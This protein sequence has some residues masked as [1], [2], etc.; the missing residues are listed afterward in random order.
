MPFDIYRKKNIGET[1]LDHISMETM[2]FSAGY[3]NR[4]F[5][6]FTLTWVV[7]FLILR[8]PITKLYLRTVDGLILFAPLV[9]ILAM[10]IL[11]FYNYRK[12]ALIWVVIRRF[13]L[14]LTLKLMIVL[15]LFYILY[16]P[17][18]FWMVI[19]PLLVY[20]KTALS[21]EGIFY[22]L[23]YFLFFI[24][25][26]E[27]L[28]VSFRAYQK[29]KG[30]YLG[31]IEIL[32]KKNLYV[33]FFIFF[34]IFASSLAAYPEAYNPVFSVI[35]D[36]I[37]T[38][39]FG[40]APIFNNEEFTKYKRI[41][42][43]GEFANTVSS[44]ISETAKELSENNQKFKI[45]IESVEQELRNSFAKV[46]EDFEEKI[47]T[48][49]ETAAESV[50]L[51]GGTI[52]ADTL[53]EGSLTMD[54]VI[55]SNSIIPTNTGYNLGSSR[56]F[57]DSLYVSLIFGSGG[58]KIGPGSSNQG[59]SNSED[60]I[61]TGNLE[62][63][64]AV[65]FDG[66]INMSGGRMNG[67][68]DIEYI[69]DDEPEYTSI[70][71]QDAVSLTYLRENLSPFYYASD[72][73]VRPRE[74][75]QD[76]SVK[77]C[78]YDNP[79][80]CG[81]M[82]SL[83]FIG[84]SIRPRNGSENFQF[85]D[86]DGD[87][88]VHFDTVNSRVWI[89]S[90][91]ENINNSNPDAGEIYSLD[92]A[93]I[94]KNGGIYLRHATTS[95]YSMQIY[96]SVNQNTVFG[97]PSFLDNYTAGAR[98]VVFGMQAARRNVSGE[99]NVFFGYGAGLYNTVGLR[100]IGIGAY[101]LYN[102]T[103]S[104]NIAIGYYSLHDNT[105]GEKNIAIAARYAMD[106]NSAGS[107]NIALGG[108]G[109]LHS[110]VEGDDNI[111]IGYFN[112]YYSTGSRN[113]SIGSS[114]LQQTQGGNDNTS[115]GGSTSYISGLVRENQT[116]IGSSGNSYGCSL[117]SASF[118]VGALYCT[119]DSLQTRD[120]SAFG[121]QALY[122]NSSENTGTVEA[123]GVNDF[124]DEEGSYNSYFGYFTN[125]A[126]N[127]GRHNSIFGSIALLLNST[128]VENT[129]F[130]YYAMASY[131]DRTDSS[132]NTVIGAQALYSDGTGSLGSDYNV[133]FGLNA[134]HFNGGNYNVA[135]G[136]YSLFDNLGDENI[137]FGFN[138]GSGNS[139]ATA[140][141]ELNRNLILGA[142][143]GITFQTPEAN[144]D[145][146][147]NILAGSISGT[148]LYSGERNIFLGY[149][150]SNNFYDGSFNIDI[151]QSVGAFSGIYRIPYLTQEDW[152]NW[153]TQFLLDNPQYEGVINFGEFIAWMNLLRNATGRYASNTLNIGNLIFGN[154]IDGTAATI[155]TGNI[156]I[157]TNAPEHR[158]TVWKDSPEPDEILFAI[159]NGTE[160]IFTVDEDGD[161]IYESSITQAADYAEHF[162]S[163]DINL[164]SGEAVCVDETKENAVKR[165]AKNGDS[166]IIGVVSTKPA[167]VGNRTDEAKANPENYPIVALLGQIPAKISNENG[168]INIGDNLASASISGMLRK[169][170]PGESTV[171][172]ALQNFTK[173]KGTIQVL[174]S[175][176][177]KSLT[178][179][180]IEEETEKRIAEMNIDDQV[181]NLLVS[182]QESLE[183]QIQSS[184]SIFQSDILSLSELNEKI[185]EQMKD[186]RE[187]YQ[188]LYDFYLVFN[189][190]NLDQIAYKNAPVNIFEG[191]VEVQNIS[192]TKL[193]AETTET[194][195]LI[196][197]NSEEK[198]PTIGEG[199]ICD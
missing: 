163:S 71:Q 44:S 7:F 17:E 106:L 121:Y 119:F 54:D 39:T 93:L 161:V 152:E 109:P 53:I 114:S 165:C 51:A 172:I 31:S 186:L 143:A 112:L 68:P 168:N 96:P 73:M 141:L 117:N 95:T 130:G 24:I 192:A 116:N 22:F 70:Y 183:N 175:R 156:G 10:S 139:G 103:V 50:E 182:A 35:G 21:F 59:L 184:F 27:V 16:A 179:E 136:P 100:N 3:Q 81:S 134:I 84:N 83:T 5:V 150:A 40:K 99:D 2:F 194:G 174:I 94:V 155:S 146:E 147:D 74:F 25:I 41:S 79:D 8:L 86:T 69:S 173:E 188:A 133:V 144:V 185:E 108:Y 88:L 46:A 37:Y 135:I 13:F 149:L 85:Q 169:A 57:F 64:D 140:S 115:I 32:V 164:K 171:G 187:S 43:I 92:T 28:F 189:P 107:R 26:V 58:L 198:S 87:S 181:N 49:L 4:I 193:I 113:T 77:L 90:G 122:G 12:H 151:G 97:A 38:I 132:Y 166:N 142:H 56:K 89:G 91:E 148:N 111:A 6:Y 191:D 30:Q 195:G 48:D 145:F 18:V 170:N 126:E 60:L 128:G 65:Y 160:N 153:F 34:F 36:T 110:N 78:E 20:A 154:D 196:I 19:K 42:S 61:V 177:N 62:I 45:E 104:D 137:V 199:R 33:L 66:G 67:L 23:S 120:N 11:A 129:V 167:I 125:T 157:G 178:V 162:F 180:N 102:S 72:E 75:Y 1:R 76:Y 158:L 105:T 159:N 127:R 29:L 123:E 131:N 82:F 47:A 176:K 14:E 124:E 63:G 80:S 138:A 15:L 9:L 52:T 118:G 55:N 101:S 190:E 98:N 197:V